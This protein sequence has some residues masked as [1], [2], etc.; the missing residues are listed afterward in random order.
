MPDFAV[1]RAKD[2]MLTTYLKDGKGVF[3]KS[4]SGDLVLFGT[5]D[6]IL[7]VDIDQDSDDDLII[8][9]S[10]AGLVAMLICDGLGNFTP[11]QPLN[12]GAPGT[13]AAADLNN[14]S[15]PDL[16]V[17]VM[18]GD[19]VRIFWGAGPGG[20][21][22]TPDIYPV[23]KTPAAAAI[24]DINGDGLLDIL[25]ADLAGRTVS[26]LA[27]R[28]GGRFESIG[29]LSVDGAPTSVAVG[30]VNGDG[31]TDVVA[32]LFEQA[33]IA[34]F[35][36]IGGGLFQPE[37]QYGT[38][39]L[40]LRVKIA[41]L[42]GDGRLEVITTGATSDRLS[43]F[44]PAQGGP[45][46]A[47]NFAT[48]R[49]SPNYTVVADFDGDGFADVAAADRLEGFVQFLR[50]GSE[51]RLASGE[52]VQ[53]GVHAG[54]MI[55][56]DF[57][58]DGKIDIALAVNGGVRL[59]AN[60]SSPGR[61][62]FNV[63]PP[64]H[65]PPYPAGTGT[66]EI[67]TGLVDDDFIPDMIVADFWGGAIHFL[68]GTGAPF[69]YQKMREPI[70]LEGAPVGLIAAQFNDDSFLDFAVAQFTKGIVSVFQGTG[71][72][73]FN[74]ILDVPVGN[75]PNYMRAADFDRN[76]WTD[77]VVSNLESDNV[78]V[79]LRIESGFLVN[80]LTVGEGPTALLA[81]DMNRDGLPDILVTSTTGADFP[82]LLG[83]GSGGFARILRFPGTF[84]A[85]SADLGDVNA[86][87]L[88]DLAVASLRTTR[89]SL[90]INQ[91][92]VLPQ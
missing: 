79:L 37:V 34:Y 82:V 74:R 44:F 27:G 33:S 11:R 81:G 9:S 53:V 26:M 15:W 55:K 73:G 30:D 78:S 86:D 35:A 25:T 23:G 13:P 46:G 77:L 7:A 75:K 66:F 71:N 70:K 58:G 88:P 8:A 12:T 52:E 45:Y 39:G 10:D 90:Y 2:R 67:V 36:G 50:G 84:E 65:Q 89:I 24:A 76:G 41:D 56:Q 29:S 16:V 32:A 59:L 49:K 85:V 80:T 91:S 43:V 6:S 28:T 64:L 38:S 61:F 31:I 47:V 5:P 69:I 17:P 3:N 22:R 62:A 4:S 83:D 54:N 40:P 19:Q 92:I 63:V 21:N 68:R 57:N 42:D 48:K 72:G 1:I 87:G 51:G 18:T 14:D 60:V 20:F